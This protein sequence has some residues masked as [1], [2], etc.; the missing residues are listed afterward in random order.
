MQNCTH[1]IWQ[2]YILYTHTQ[3]HMHTE[4]TGRKI[5]QSVSSGDFGGTVELCMIFFLFIPPKYS[6]SVMT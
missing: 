6:G 2:L 4:E 3:T 1:N 5:H